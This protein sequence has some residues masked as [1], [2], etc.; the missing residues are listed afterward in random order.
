MYVRNIHPLSGTML[1][2]Y[3]QDAF[4]P[5]NTPIQLQLWSNLV[6]EGAAIPNIL[7]CQGSTQE[8][9][10]PLQFW[11]LAIRRAIVYQA[12]SDQWL[13]SQRAPGVS[14]LLT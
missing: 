14:V 9:D 8:S 11:S 2:Y 5:Y 10:S 12:G 4:N 3:L 6:A 7:Y 13:T 1:M